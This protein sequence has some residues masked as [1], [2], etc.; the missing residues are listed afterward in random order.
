MLN[1]YKNSTILAQEFYN[2]KLKLQKRID[3]WNEYGT[4]PTSYGER[5]ES[6]IRDSYENMLDIGCG[7]AQY[8]SRWLKY[9]K[10]SATF[11][12]ISQDL[13][14]V[15]SKNILEFNK[16]NVKINIKKENFLD[17]NFGSE[18][19]D[20]VIAMHVLQHIDNI[21]CALE[22]INMLSEPNGTIFITT[23]DNTLDDWLNTTHY[24]LLTDL[25][26]PL[27]MLN[28]DQYLSF[29]GENA[30]QETR[31]V[32]KNIEEIKFH[33][34]AIVTDCKKLLEYYESS[35]MF[36]MS[37]GRRSKDVS[38]QQWYKLKQQMY[39]K[40]K[41]EMNRNGYILVKGRVQILKIKK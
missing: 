36:R 8:S 19:Y 22:K 31:K 7:N 18:K 10:K 28:K 4:N 39:T 34:D 13:L 40:I 1:G 6:L 14:N 29:S 3:F 11:M 15:A 27:R 9:L 17:E 35:M 2:D 32:F 21:S 23:Y 30:I 12:D 37:E 5:L 16:N 33:N 20:L 26:F 25:K 38:N 41:D 24:Q